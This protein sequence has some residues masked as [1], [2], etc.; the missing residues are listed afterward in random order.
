MSTGCTLASASGKKRRLNPR[1]Q[2]E[3]VHGGAHGAVAAVIGADAARASAKTLSRN[4][5][6]LF[7][8]LDFSFT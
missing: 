2:H 8:A 3:V 7:G 1:S 5:C 6:E 4:K